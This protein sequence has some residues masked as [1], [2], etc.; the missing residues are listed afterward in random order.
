MSLD[1]SRRNGGARPRTRTSSAPS[2]DAAARPGRPAAEVRLPA[3]VRSLAFVGL[4]LLSLLPAAARAVDVPLFERTAHEVLVVSGTLAY[5]CSV[6]HDE[7]HIGTVSLQEIDLLTGTVGAPETVYTA[8]TF[9]SD[10]VTTDECSLALSG[11]GNHLVVAYPVICVPGAG[12][13]CALTTLLGQTS[14]KDLTAGTWQTTLQVSTP[15]HLWSVPAD[16]RVFELDGAYLLLYQR[17]Q[18]SL[19]G[20]ALQTQYFASLADLVAG[21]E[22]VLVLDTTDDRFPGSLG[23]YLDAPMGLVHWSYMDGQISQP[24]TYQFG[25]VDA[26]GQGTSETPIQDSLIAASGTDAH[27][28]WAARPFPWRYDNLATGKTYFL[29]LKPPYAIAGYRLVL[30]ELFRTADWELAAQ[31]SGYYALGG[32]DTLLNPAA[33]EIYGFPFTMDALLSSDEQWVVASRDFQTSRLALHRIPAA[34]PAADGPEQ[35]Q[36]GT[37][38]PG[39]L[40]CGTPYSVPPSHTGS[41]I[42]NEPDFKYQNDFVSM[43][44]L[45]NGQDL[46]I[47]YRSCPDGDPAHAALAARI[48]PL[49]F[50]RLV[51]DAYETLKRGQALTVPAPGLLAN[52]SELVAPTLAVFEPPPH[53]A[54]EL[55]QDGA[56]VYTPTPSFCGT[57]TFV[58]SVAQGGAT[59]L[60]RAS[61]T[62]HCPALLWWTFD[63][64]EPTDPPTALALN[65]RLVDVGSLHRDAAVYLELP[66]D[67][68]LV[69]PGSPLTGSPAALD[70]SG[71]ESELIRFLPGFAD[72]NDGGPAAGG[73]FDF[74]AASDITIEAIVRLPV[75][76]SSFQAIVGKVTGS[77]ALTSWFLEVSNTGVLQAQL[78][79]ETSSVVITGATP[80]DDGEWHH[81]AW[82]RE[83]AAQ[84]LRLYVDGELD[85]TTPDTTTGNMITTSPI[86][87]GAFGDDGNFEH[88]FNGQIDEARVVFF[89]LEPSEFLYSTAHHPHAADDIGGLAPDGGARRIVVTANDDF[90]LDGPGTTPIEIGATAH[91]SAIVDDGGTPAD[92]SDDALWVTPAPGHTGPATVAYAIRDVDGDRSEATLVLEVQLGIFNDGFE[93]GDTSAW[94]P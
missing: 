15:F 27:G 68:P 35:L 88:Q 42:G 33:P 63:E 37:Q 52:D 84:E 66:D 74:G 25:T 38:L 90:G 31:A 80:V 8:P 76:S 87:A 79:D 10:E 1:R 13:P 6:A 85:A 71:S 41:P 61:V 14:V 86:A 57:D 91:A 32:S 47:V 21:T 53:G 92:P 55:D 54:I 45:P 29:V 44:E 89:P 17:L 9:V 2:T 78:A 62:V 93:S 43:T 82:V 83:F 28:T 73:G 24:A 34:F 40:F 60:A 3:C 51:D 22:S 64:L 16:L 7:N 56:F 65:D 70:F 20:S 5:V 39:A 36:P 69:V 58:Y 12:S 46:L 18:D 49:D 48:V 19:S 26:A 30:R 50:P 81:V 67:G 72:F 77:G 94:S 4:G 75:P 59:Y 23:A 11:D